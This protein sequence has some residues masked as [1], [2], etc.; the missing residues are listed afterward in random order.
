M[1]NR[2]KIRRIRLDKNPVGWHQPDEVVSSPV[3]EGD[4]S[5]EGDVPTGVEGSACERRPAREAVEHTAHAF[6]ARLAHHRGRIGV[7]VAG[8]DYY[9]PIKSPGELQLRRKCA[10]LCISG[11]IVVVIVK[12]AFADSRGAGADQALECGDIGAQLERRGIVRMNSSGECD[13][14]RMRCRDP[15]RFL[16]LLDRCADAD[17]GLCARQAG[18]CDYRVTVAD[19]V[20]VREVGVAVDEPFHA[21]GCAL[22]G[23]LC[24]IQSSTGPAM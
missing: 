1:W 12:P 20:L 17:N 8:M 3:P 13:E 16:C 19:E 4:Y 14:A 22:R 23:Y 24:S 7:C 11:R 21:D 10:S 5:A 15:G 9:G 18:A 2:S 6:P